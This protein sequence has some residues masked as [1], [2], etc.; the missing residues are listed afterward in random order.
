MNCEGFVLES[1][2]VTFV[3]THFGKRGPECQNSIKKLSILYSKNKDNEERGE[4]DLDSKNEREN[5]K[6]PG[7]EKESENNKKSENKDNDYELV[8]FIKT[9]TNGD[10]GGE[11]KF[12]IS[13]RLWKL[14]TALLAYRVSSDSVYRDF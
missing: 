2:V 3:P 10:E 11:S 13:K 8:E 14:L 1:R 7:I 5:D 6:E 9:T 12:M 4:F